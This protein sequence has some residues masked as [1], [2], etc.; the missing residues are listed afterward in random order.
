MFIRG[1]IE[2]L[3][4]RYYRICEGNGWNEMSRG[5]VFNIQRYSLHD[6]PGIRTTVFLKGCPL[7]CWWCHN[8]ES[9]QTAIEFSYQP[10]LCIKCFLC[11]NNC[12]KG[13]ILFLKNGLERDEKACDGCR[14]CEKNCPS[15]SIEW[16]GKVMTV[17]EVMAEIER[18][19]IFYDESRGGVTFSGGEPLMQGEFLY[20]LLLECKDRGIHT[21]VD[22]SG[23]AP[24]SLFERIS[25]LTDLFLFDIKHIDDTVHRKTTGVSNKII[26]ENLERLNGIHKQI[27][28]R[29]PIIPEIN[30]NT[31]LTKTCQL[32]HKMQLKDI[33][34]LPY[35][36]MG[37]D[38]YKKMKEIYPLAGTVVHSADKV[39]EIAEDI[40]KWGFNVKIG[41]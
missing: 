12:P 11:Q 2:L 28:V 17:Q 1:I 35:H 31:N 33:N 14:S 19:R 27:N 22:T 29:L 20:Q 13:A 8:P 26:L 3:V 34:I 4:F 24:W 10:S 7:N 18:D 38:K 9:K 39:K 40:K 32:L 37:I 15:G 5:L 41:G 6:G 30:D 23:Y 16:I 36:N 21:A 25:S